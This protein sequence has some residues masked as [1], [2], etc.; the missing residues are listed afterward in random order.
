MTATATQADVQFLSWPRP[1]ERWEESLRAL[2]P[3]SEELWNR[4]QL[5]DVAPARPHCR[6]YAVAGLLEG[7]GASTAAAALAHYLAQELGARVLLVEADLRTPA[8]RRLGLV[9][10]CPGFVG[11]LQR[12]ARLRHVVFELTRVGFHALPAGATLPSPSALID[13]TNLSRFVRLAEPYFDVVLLD[14]PPLTLAPEARHLI[15]R[16][17][18][19]I[20]VLRSG[21]A[22][23]EQVA[24]WIAKIPEYGGTVG[25]VCLNAVEAVLPARLRALF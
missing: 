10:R 15:A 25:A 3:H 17:D 13:P 18:A 20:P 7:D 19:T 2:L 11:L 21:R 6:V 14:S 23:P 8:L 16:A 5:A 9:P 4:V 12:Q 22:L 24:Y 1:N